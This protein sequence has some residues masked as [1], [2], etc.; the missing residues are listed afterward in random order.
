MRRSKKN[1]TNNNWEQQRD[2]MY[3]SGYKQRRQTKPLGQRNNAQDTSALQ[4]TQEST[5]DY[6]QQTTQTNYVQN[7]NLNDNIDY[8]QR[9]NRAN[10]QHGYQNAH[11]QST[12]TNHSYADARSEQKN[13]SSPWQFEDEEESYYSQQMDMYSASSRN[14]HARPTS[15]EK[16]TNFLAEHPQVGIILAVICFVLLVLLVIRIPNL[17]ST[18]SQTNQ[19]SSE[20][21]TQQTQLEQLKKDNSELQSN[22]DSMQA[23]IDAYN[24][25]KK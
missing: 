4:E 3:Q 17:F 21:A 18:L 19:T 11:N 20:V 22:I 5:Y 7:R 1:N 10:Y 8:S 9:L 13:E 6:A 2:A 23:T 16:R 12:R 15:M 24:A 25:T 14:Y